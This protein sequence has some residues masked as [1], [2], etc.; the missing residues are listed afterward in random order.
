MGY[1]Y[2]KARFLLKHTERF[3]LITYLNRHPFIRILVENVFI[4][5]EDVVINTK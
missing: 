1:N 3:Y 2:N 5:F 4:K